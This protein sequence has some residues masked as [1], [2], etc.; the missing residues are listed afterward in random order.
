MRLLHAVWT[1][2][3]D[4][5]VE[6]GSIAVGTLVALAL[7]G[8]CAAIPAVRDAGGWLLLAL[9]MGLLLANLLRAGQRARARLRDG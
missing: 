5:L 6:D 7:T 4:L 8:V 9:L 2:I 3:W 1:N